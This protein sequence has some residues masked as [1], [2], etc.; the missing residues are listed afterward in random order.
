MSKAKPTTSGRTFRILSTMSS[1]GAMTVRETTTGETYAIV[2]YVDEILKERFA[3]LEKGAVAR[4]ELRPID[5]SDQ[6]C[7]ATKLRPGRPP[8]PGL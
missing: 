3:A 1:N 6:V 7:A 4:L 5:G 8:V 2:E